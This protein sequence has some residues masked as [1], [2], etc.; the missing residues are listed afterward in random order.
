MKNPRVEIQTDLFPSDPLTETEQDELNDLLLSLDSDD[1]ITL[2]VLEGYLAG[3]LCCPVKL[4][5]QE[6][7]PPIWGGKEAYDATSEEDVGRIVDLVLQHYNHVKSCLHEPDRFYEP[8]FALDTDEFPLWE[9][10]AEGFDFAMHIGERGWKKVNESVVRKPGASET[11][12]LLMALIDLG[13]D[14]DLVPAKERDEM[15]RS[16]YDL[17]PGLTKSTYELNARGKIN[18]PEDLF[19]AAADAI[20]KVGRNDLCPCGSGKKYKKCHGA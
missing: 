12:G 7:F 16:A 11:L 3:I 18:L 19:E 9:L 2:P 15:R 5:P 10:W 4:K 1:A 20:P 14:G 17:I 13:T 8:I 6:W